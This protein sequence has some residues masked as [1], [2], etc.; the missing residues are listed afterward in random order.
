M[1]R[2]FFVVAA[3]FFFFAAVGVTVI[4]NPT[5]WGLVLT[6]LGLAAGNWSP[7]PWPGRKPVA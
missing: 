4:P 3:L 5:A 1:G 7:W 2:V 6:A